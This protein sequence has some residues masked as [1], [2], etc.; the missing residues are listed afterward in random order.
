MNNNSQPNKR[1]IA[2]LS[3]TFPKFSETF[4]VREYKYLKKISDIDIHPF[5]IRRPAAQRIDRDNDDLLNDTFYLRPD[6]AAGVFYANIVLMII[7]PLK[8]FRTM[9]LMARSC[10]FVPPTEWSK[11][12]FHF[13]SGAYLARV[14][15]KERYDSIHAHFESAGNI[16]LFAHLIGGI[17]YTVTFHAGDDLYTGFKPLLEDKIRCA[18]CVVTNNRYNIFFI[19]LLTG[20]RHTDKIRLIYNG[21]DPQLFRHISPH[22]KIDGKMRLLNIGTFTQM[23]GYPVVL[24][25]LRVLKEQNIDFE[26]HIVGDGDPREKQMVT[27]LV[28]EYGLEG[29]VQ[30]L[31]IIPFSEAL[32]QLEWCHVEIMNSV[33]GEAG[34]RDGL[35]NAII[36]AMLSGRPV[37]STYVSD[38][39]NILKHENTGYL[40][41]E[42]DPA[43]LA[44][45]L[46]WINGHYDEA[47]GVAETAR[48]FA[49][50]HFDIDRNY[51]QLA[52]LLL[53]Q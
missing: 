52:G 47:A 41:P 40:V 8:Y 35:P 33:I 17:E 49:L 9:A 26:Y 5:A 36:E 34:A 1:K 32:K 39:P 3:A 28:S 53:E 37:V 42:R 16:A 6:H 13:F 24:Q 43:A 44:D 31:G 15:K 21:V 46:C 14:L 30:L 2:F 23:K 27:R 29:R 11:Y 20:Y 50:K 19:N 45:R 38:I 7:S 12:L 10:F 22:G 48:E 51:K 4:I 18:R 25:A